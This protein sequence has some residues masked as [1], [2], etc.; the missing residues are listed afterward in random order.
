MSACAS[1]VR[2]RNR[3]RSKVWWLQAFSGLLLVLSCRTAGTTHAH[4]HARRCSR[5]ACLLCVPVFDKDG[6]AWLLIRVWNWAVYPR[7]RFSPCTQQPSDASPMFQYENASQSKTNGPLGPLGAPHQGT[8]S[9][10]PGACDTPTL[11][12]PRCALLGPRSLFLPILDLN[13]I[14]K[15]LSCVFD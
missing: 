12:H 11:T 2:S 10:A 8:A 3:P 14:L 15:R 4:Q 6:T 13:Q 7:S 1:S 5:R 9:M